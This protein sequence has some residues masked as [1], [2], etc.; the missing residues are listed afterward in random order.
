MKGF[1][2]YEPVPPLSVDGVRIHG[3][4][5]RDNANAL[6]LWRQGCV[7]PVDQLVDDEFKFEPELIKSF[8]LQKKSFRISAPHP[9]GK[10]TVY[11]ICTVKNGK[12]TRADLVK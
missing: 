8:R 12:W 11:A 7:E 3:W 6:L 9:T 1:D 5:G 2:Y 10:G 4:K